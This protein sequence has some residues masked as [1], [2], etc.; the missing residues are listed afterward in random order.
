MSWLFDLVQNSKKLATGGPLAVHAHNT[1]TLKVFALFIQLKEDSEF[2]RSIEVIPGEEYIAEHY[3]LSR[4]Q[5]WCKGRY[6][7]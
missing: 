4:V 3:D 2:Y 7:V 6:K 1:Y 5:H